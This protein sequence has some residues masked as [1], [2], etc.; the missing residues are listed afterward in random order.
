MT[1]DQLPRTSLVQMQA[2]SP[3]PRC[4]VGQVPYTITARETITMD[5]LEVER[6][7]ETQGPCTPCV[8]RGDS[9]PWT[10]H[11]LGMLTDTRGRGWEVSRVGGA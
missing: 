5:G 11:E 6:L 3:C 10:P 4:F 2:H 8:L 7:G 9:A 1:T